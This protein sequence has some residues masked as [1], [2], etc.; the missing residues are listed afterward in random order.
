MSAGLLQPLPVKLEYNGAVDNGKTQQPD[1]A[2][3]DAAEYAGLEVQDEDLFG[4]R[5]EQ[6]WL[7]STALL[8]CARPPNTLVI[9]ASSSPF[10]MGAA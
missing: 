3:S 4:G 6:K 1:P 7:L 5:G 8:L 9:E 2:E 10:C